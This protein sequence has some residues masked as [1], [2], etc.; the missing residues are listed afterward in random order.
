MSSTR[1]AARLAISAK[2][3]RKVPA[4][5]RRRRDWAPNMEKYVMLKCGHVALPWGAI[6][7]LGS[8][9]SHAICDECD[10]WQPISRKAHLYEVMGNEPTPELLF[11]TPPF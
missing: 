11:N 5:P 6:R 7:H 9:V 1:T 3:L 10:T 2:S 4:P 8:L